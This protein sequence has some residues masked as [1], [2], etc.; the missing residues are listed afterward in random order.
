VARLAALGCDV[1]VRWP[2]SLRGRLPGEE[3]VRELWELGLA[4][5]PPGDTE[6]R[7]RLLGIRAGW[8]FAFSPE[9]YSVGELEELAATG[10]EGGEMALRMGLPNRASAAYDQALA[11]W[12]ALGWYGRTVPIWERR[13]EIA[14]RVTDVLEL[15]DLYAMGAWVHHEVGRY[16]RSVEIADAGLGKVSGR[17]PS[18]ELHLRAWRVASLY[19]LGRWDEAI[20]EFASIRRMLE[21]REDDPPYFVTHAFGIAGVLHQRRGERVQSDGLAAAMLGMMRMST[22]GSGRLFPSLLRFL[23][24]RGDLAQAREL[25]RPNNWAVHAGAA[26]EAEAERLAAAEEWNG[27]DDLVSE[28]RRHADAANAPSVASFADRLE[29]RAALVSGQLEQAVQSL[30]RALA[31]FDS[32]GVP[33][34]RA[35]TELDLARASS[36]AGDRPKTSELAAR[37]AATFEALRDTE[38]AAAARALMGSD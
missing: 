15:G 16:D 38:G 28:M 21:N 9:R 7:I 33:W 5:L 26:M 11:P 3:A 22:E 6:E 34:E 29:G 4:H 14:D 2:G 35:L 30:E 27:A 1:A 19:R 25:R 18:V 13:A 32:L 12:L 17:G 36:I 23:V 8:P 10:L 24:V 31:G 20:E 37:A